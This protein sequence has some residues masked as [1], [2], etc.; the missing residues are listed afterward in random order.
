MAATSYHIGSLMQTKSS[1]EIK[2]SKKIGALEKTIVESCN[3][4][5]KMLNKLGNK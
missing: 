4:H 1:D 3:V 5:K 2:I